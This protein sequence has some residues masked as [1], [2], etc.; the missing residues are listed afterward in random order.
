MK[1]FSELGI[2][3]ADSDKIFN[4]QQVS[5]TD[6]LNSEIEVIG[7]LPNVKTKHG[8]G[9]YLVHFKQVDN[10]VEGK[11]LHELRLAEKRPRPSTGRGLPL[12]LGYQGTTV[13]ER[14]T[15]SVYIRRGGQSDL[16]LFG[17]LERSRPISYKGG[18]FTTL[19]RRISDK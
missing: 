8:E 2:K 16:R 19:V 9:R 4:C 5:I 13:R 7:F 11:V 6:I 12:Y 1:R 18:G 14:E 10:G 3:Q 17:G 15:V